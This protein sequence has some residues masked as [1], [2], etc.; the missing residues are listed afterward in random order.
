MYEL[1]LFAGGGGGILAGHLLGWK[2]VG[3]VEIERY[4]RRV[5]LARQRDGILPWFPIWDDIT[6]FR[7]DN[8]ECREYIEWLISI[9]DELVVSGGFPC[10]DISPARTNSHINGAISGIHG[11]SSGLWF[12]M[13]RVLKEI[14]PRFAFIENSKN[15]RT[16]GLC[17]VLKGLSRMGYNAK[18]GVLGPRAF[19]ADHIRGRMWIT[20]SLANSDEPQLQGG[21]V[22]SRVHQKDADA[23]GS[24]WWKDQP[25]LERVANGPSS[26]LDAN[27][28]KRLKAIG[29][30]QV[31]IVAATA[32]RV[33]TQ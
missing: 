31:P 16:N 14:R 30:A 28:G 17:G 25:N 15:L 18:W 20:A 21:S 12:E 26:G 1:A 7:L 13:E 23:I 11:T 4:P 27:W 2:C 3:A 33:L 6:T 29:N 8:P 24:N 9:R 10:T 32:W 22:S 19:G 5:L